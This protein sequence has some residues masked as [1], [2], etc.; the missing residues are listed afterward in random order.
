MQACDGRHTNATEKAHLS[1]TIRNV[2]LR[3]TESTM[4]QMLALF[5]LAGGSPGVA[6]IQSG[7]E[8]AKDDVRRCLPVGDRRNRT[9]R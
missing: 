8:S 6:L 1:G 2:P 7:K 3:E 4:K 9:S 5:L